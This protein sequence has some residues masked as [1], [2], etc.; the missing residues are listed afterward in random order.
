[1]VVIVSDDESEKQYIQVVA[2]SSGGAYYFAFDQDGSITKKEQ[3]IQTPCNI[4]K[5][6]DLP[7]SNSTIMTTKPLKEGIFLIGTAAPRHNK[8]HV[9]MMS[10][11]QDDA[12]VPVYVGSL[13]GHEDWITCFDWIT[14]TKSSSSSSSSN[15]FSYM[16]SG[17]QD[18]KIRLWKWVT[19]TTT[20]STK[21]SH[22]T[23]DPT[24]PN[25]VVEGVDDSEEDEGD[26]D[27]EEEMFEGEARLELIHNDTKNKEPSYLTSVYLDAL[28]IGHE[29]MVIISMASQSKTII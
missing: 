11:N 25:M 27:D 26:D 18:A 29:E 24:I 2:C 13:T 16:A 5:Y 14:P 8:I 9:L 1:M 21:S 12:V 19:T 23:N 10:H 7:L 15:C 3:L 4:V 20:A 28:L 22:S 17:S 6:Y